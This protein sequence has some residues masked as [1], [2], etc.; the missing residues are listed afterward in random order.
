MI[1]RIFEIGS[2]A[3]FVAFVFYLIWVFFTNP[4][5]GYAAPVLLFFPLLMIGGLGIVWIIISCVKSQLHL[6]TKVFLIQI[7]I[8]L[9]A[10]II[11][12]IIFINRTEARKISD[13]TYASLVK[14]HPEFANY[15]LRE[16]NENYQTYSFTYFNDYLSQGRTLSKYH[17][18]E[19][20]LTSRGKVK[21]IYNV[22]DPSQTYS[23]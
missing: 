3:I 20:V 18:V 21:E 12:K 14:K 7:A 9:F 19:I 5:A 17:P 2:T 4:G 15:T 23:P 22:D 16:T 1:F 13:A 8:C 6:P 10:F 11:T